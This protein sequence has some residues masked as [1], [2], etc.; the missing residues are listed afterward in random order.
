MRVRPEVGYFGLAG[1]ALDSG[2]GAPGVVEP[3]AFP[4]G[5]DIRVRAPVMPFIETNNATIVGSADIEVT[6]TLD[7]PIITGRIELDRGEFKFSGN[8]YRLQAGSIDFSNPLKF[9]P[10]FDVSATTRVRSTGQT[11]DIT[12]RLSGTMST[13]DPQINS[14]PWLPEFQ[15]V[16]LLFGETPDVGSAEVRARTAPQELQAQALRT[17]MVALLASPVSS[18]VGSVVERATTI[19][20]VQIVPLLGNEMSIQQLNPTARITLGKRISNRVYL[21]YARTISGSQNE[22]ILIEIDQNDQIS[23]V[24]SRN[25]DRTFAVDFRI[26]HVF[27]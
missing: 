24:L 7:R 17:A 27:K 6:G 8:R 9:D 4:M 18:T 3:S 13:L 11:Y 25:E 5:L 21:T 2:G 22:I 10:F 15:V 23:W 19:D 14:E 16:S 26:K 12:L 1:G 20:T